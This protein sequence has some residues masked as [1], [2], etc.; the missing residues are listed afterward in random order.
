MPP[1][2]ADL[3]QMLKDAEYLSLKKLKQHSGDDFKANQSKFI[4]GYDGN[5][6]EDFGKVFSSNQPT[7]MMEEPKNSAQN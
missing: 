4:A 5:R 2:D 6:F 1:S 3:E 7:Y